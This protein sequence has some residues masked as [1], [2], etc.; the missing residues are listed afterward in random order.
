LRL[1]IKPYAYIYYSH[2]NTELDTL[3][4]A[5]GDTIRLEA[6]SS[7]I[8]AFAPREDT[9]KRNVLA[10]FNNFKAKQTKAVSRIN[11]LKRLFY[12]VDRNSAPLE[13]TNDYQRF[14][15]YPV[16]VNRRAITTNKIALNQLVYWQLDAFNKSANFLKSLKNETSDE[17]VNT[18]LYKEQA[19]LFARLQELH[20]IARSD[21]ALQ[22]LRSSLFINDDLLKNPYG[23]TYIYTYLN[24]SALTGKSEFSRS[25]QYKDY[26]VAYDSSSRFFSDSLSKYVRYLSLVA[27][28]NWGESFRETEK[29]FDL[30]K[31]QYKDAR[32]N[33][34]LEEKYLFSAK[35]YSHLKDDVK[36][37]DNVNNVLSLK[38]IIRQSKGK[39]IY[40]DF[41][42]SWCAP[43]RAAM[44]SSRKLAKLTTHKNVVMLYLSLDGDS[45]KWKRASLAEN[46]DGYEH[47]YRV[48]NT[49]AASFLKELN[50]KAIPRY[51]LFDQAGRLVHQDAPGPG[52]K[53]IVSLLVGK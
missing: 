42:A 25:R 18:L 2:R 8:N 5:Q 31:S 38:D 37:Y 22:L 30:F 1:P 23:K 32:L 40:I 12:E 17:L 35:K 48:I 14:T 47:N 39:R 53:E 15:T 45:D 44:P 46:L 41:W 20:A 33:A 21:S 50:I 34:I 19:T 7:S 9:L 10:K 26:K 36:L 4:V 28:V 13:G 43:C 52:S 27:T 6:T 3:L 24:N 16:S 51:L 11:S 29:R 49:A